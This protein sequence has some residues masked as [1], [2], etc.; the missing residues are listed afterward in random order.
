MIN[1]RLIG[2]SGLKRCL[3]CKKSSFSAK[4]KISCNFFFP[5][6]PKRL[7]VFKNVS[8]ICASSEKIVCASKNRKKMDFQKLSFN[9]FSKLQLKT[10]VHLVYTQH[11]MLPTRARVGSWSVWSFRLPQPPTAQPPH[12]LHWKIED[13]YSLIPIIPYER[14]RTGT[15]SETRASIAVLLDSQWASIFNVSTNI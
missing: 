2:P 11:Y 3:K 4:K 12:R 15:S 1:V 10:C 9:F 8:T 5:P 7:Y 14:T 6:L 13:F